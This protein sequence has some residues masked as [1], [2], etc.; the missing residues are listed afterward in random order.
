[1]KKLSIALLVAA[2][3]MGLMVGG[4]AGKSAK[5]T[6]GTQVCV[7]LPDTTTSVR[8]EQFD[9]PAFIAAFKKAG[10]TAA[11]VN[12]LGQQQKQLAQA[13]QCINDGAKV[14][15]ITSLDTGTSIAIQKKFAAA[16]GKSIDYDRQIVGGIGAVYISFDGNAV[17]RIQARGVISGMVAKKTYGP[18]GVIAELWGGPTDANAFWFKSGNDDVLNPLFKVKKVT[19]GPAKFVPNWDSKNAQTIFEQML[20]QTNNN[21]QG[22]VAAND[23]IAGAVVATLKAKGLKPIPLSGQDATVQ[24]VQ[25]IISGWQ[26]NTVYKYV[27]DEANAAAAAAVALFKGKAPKTNSTRPNG[28]QEAADAGDPGCVDHEG[29]LHAALHGQV[30]EAQRRVLRGSTSSTASRSTTRVE[31]PPGASTVVPSR[32]MSDTPLLEIRGLSKTFGSVQALTEVDFE[33]RKGE[34]MALVG[35]NGAGKSTLIKCIAGIH[36]YDEG[37]IVFDGEPVT[38]HSPKDAAR[39][40]IE[41]VYQ[42]LALCDNLDVVQNM[43]LGREERDWLYRLKEPVMEQRTVETLRSLAVTTISSIR[44][45]VASLSGGQ[46]QSV[47]VAKA[48]QWNSRLVILDEPTAALGVAQTRQVL[49]LVKRLAEQGLAVVLVSHNLHD[50]FEV[51]TRI[52]VLR[53]GRDVGVYEREATTQQEV[54]TAITAG[55]PTKVAGIAETAGD[56]L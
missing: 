33:V 13:E 17:G 27:P 25:N 45:P 3:A 26:T 29:E 1:M 8:W 41:V 43:F 22:V 40:G 52:T 19:K 2:V 12:A 44:Q 39:L 54:V 24:G 11:V 50:I 31:A 49:D 23:G 10:L 21:I 36:G 55:I 47:A 56:T 18:K 4:A 51:A 48:V 7:L 53:L 34:V 30:P 37:E 32:P 38:I 14:G 42:D 35:D 15:I 20:V 5:T 9:K 46:R 6:A 16:G 28:T